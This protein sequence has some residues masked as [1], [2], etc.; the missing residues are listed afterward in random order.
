MCPLEW[1]NILS[2]GSLFINDLKDLNRYQRYRHF[3][4]DSFEVALTG[5]IC[6]STEPLLSEFMELDNGEHQLYKVIQNWSS[7][8]IKEGHLYIKQL[9]SAV[10]N[11]TSYCL[12]EITKSVLARIFTVHLLFFEQVDTN[13]RLSVALN[14]KM[15]LSSCSELVLAPR[16]FSKCVVSR[17][18]QILMDAMY[19]H[20]CWE[21][22]P[23]PELVPLLSKRRSQFG[24]YVLVEDDNGYAMFVKFVHDEK[25]RSY[26]VQYHIQTFPNQVTVEMV[27]DWPRGEFC[28]ML[29]QSS[30]SSSLFAKIYEKVKNR[31]QKCG[32][33]LRSRRNLLSVFEKNSCPKQYPGNQTDDVERLLAYSSKSR[34][35]LRFFDTIS[36]EANK[37]LADLTISLLLSNSFDANVVKLSISQDVSAGGL[38]LGFWFL[39]RHGE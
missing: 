22:L 13:V 18:R 7:S 6:I 25:G 33:A 20:E 29:T 37:I 31:D 30:R 32:R 16:L 36:G 10:G 39:L 26:L 2:E 28:G 17:S 21:L 24:K 34:I 35:K 15:M 14:L 8:T 38:G 23:D 3:R 12:L 1:G 5:N 11:L 4:M 9:P 19:H 27:M